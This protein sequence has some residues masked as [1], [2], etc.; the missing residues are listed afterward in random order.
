MPGEIALLMQC[1]RTANVCARTFSEL[2]VLTRVVFESIAERYTEDRATIEKI[3]TEKYDPNVLKVIMK[4]QQN[5]RASTKIDLR[6]EKQS[7]EVL[8]MCKSM[9]Y[10]LL[11]FK[12]RITNMEN[13]QDKFMQDMT[14][15]LQSNKAKLNT[16]RHTVVTSSFAGLGQT[17]LQ[18][19]MT[20]SLP[21]QSSLGIEEEMETWVDNTMPCMN[22]PK[23]INLEDSS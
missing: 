18:D 14:M 1:K 6:L 5:A 13:K 4:Q 3:I 15:L 9:N 21:K 20:N 19:S 11:A 12:D 2:C 7:E 23:N 10:H 8:E 22:S 17:L 16:P